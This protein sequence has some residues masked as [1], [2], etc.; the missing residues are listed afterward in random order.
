M[1]HIKRQKR[2]VD[3]KVQSALIRQT[4]FHWIL[5][6]LT[7]L[8]FVFILQVLTGGPFRPWSYHLGQV[9]TRYAP[10]IIALVVVIPPVIYDSLRLSHRFVGPV[11]RLRAAMHELAHG[12]RAEP[13]HF[14]KSDFW[15]DLA[16]DYNLILEQ[17][18]SDS[19]EEE[20]SGHSDRAETEI[21][22]ELV[23]G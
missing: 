8:F 17:I 1:S 9:W 16:D 13:I 23:S 2:Y 14:R 20:A 10:F 21:T 11:Y 22:P 19:S 18:Q 12:G 6:L 5:I 4:L 15:K 3:P 7:T